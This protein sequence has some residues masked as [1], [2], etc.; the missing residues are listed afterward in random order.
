MTEDPFDLRRFVDAQV[1]SYEHA[2]VELLAGRKRGHWM[3]FVFPQLKGLGRSWMA[4]RYGVTSLAEASAYLAH[5]VLGSRLIECVET[6]NG[7]KGRS[8]LEIFGE[9]DAVK[10]RS[11][12]TLFASAGKDADVFARALDKYYG[13]EE[14]PLT[15]ELLGFQRRAA[16]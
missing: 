2:R 16:S 4:E 7:L 8:A 12:L 11:C 1:A 10:L 5:P 15:I 14:D 9:I 13:G 6:L 3:W